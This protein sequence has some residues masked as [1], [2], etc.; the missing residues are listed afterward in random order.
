MKKNE[1]D[2]PPGDAGKRAPMNPEPITPDPR[3]PLPEAVVQAVRPFIGPV[4]ASVGTHATIL[5]G[6]LRRELKSKRN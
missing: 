3:L 5:K 1:R 6:S 2:A 4:V